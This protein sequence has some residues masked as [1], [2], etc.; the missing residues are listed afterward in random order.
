VTSIT[1]DESD[2][3]ITSKVERQ[4]NLGSSRS[5]DNIE[6]VAPLGALFT[7]VDL[8]RLACTPL[9]QWTEQL[10]GVLKPVRLG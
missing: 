8:R 3:C 10:N 1:N 7:I 2:A 4:L 6:R 9:V 5:I